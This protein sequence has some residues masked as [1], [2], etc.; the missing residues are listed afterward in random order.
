MK[1]G[2][3]KVNEIH[4]NVRYN[5]KKYFELQENIKMSNQMPLV[6]VLMPCYNHDKYLAQAIDSV[7]A[8]TYPNIELLIMDNASTDSSYE[9]MKQYGDKIKIFRL[10]KNDVFK[11]MYILRTNS[12]GKYIAPI[13]ADD[14]W[15]IDKIEKQVRYLEDN[16]K[17]RAC[18]TWANVVDDNGNLVAD[19]GS[20]ICNTFFAQ[21]NRSRYAWLE[22]LIIGGN[23]LSYP[24]AMM[25][26]NAY[27]DA[28]GK[29]PPVWQLGDWNIWLEILLKGD[30]HIIEEE[31]TY[32]RWHSR[33]T[34]QNVSAPSIKSIIRT[35]NEKA[36]IAAKIINDMDEETFIKTFQKYFVRPEALGYRE[37]LCEKFFLL[38]ALASRTC[39][40]EQEV[41]NFYY[42]H[43]Q[44]VEQEGYLLKDALD[45]F[46]DYSLN[47][48]VEYCAGHGFG[49][50]NIVK[51]QEQNERIQLAK[52]NVALL[53]RFEN[54]SQ[55]YKK[56]EC[57]VMNQQRWLDALNLVMK[58]DI[59]ESK[60]N[61]VI[62]NL[63]YVS[64]ADESKELVELILKCIENIAGEIS[65]KN[66]EELQQ[67]L[68]VMIET[69][70][71]LK[72]ALRGIWIN[73]LS[74]DTELN[75]DEWEDVIVKIENNQVDENYFIEI[76]LPF[77]VNTYAILSEYRG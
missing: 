31:L 45:E 5:I 7:L 35:N 28:M 40:Y 73:F 25:H 8:Q 69:V 13:S 10:E 74:L 70:G 51:N 30:I 71:L 72:V 21:K 17:V 26:R 6:S 52:S 64:L 59:P 12:C 14:Y 68:G 61:S 49:Y 34:D 77:L 47:D 11:A 24:S 1:S 20:G 54:L 56:Q 33:G 46:Y 41:M 67:G 36:I 62:R 22:R 53:E 2:I 75:K 38:Q 29:M 50:V 57:I 32:F 55:A 19:D 48:F 9:V 37:I 16:T 42:Q 23:C 65:S 18:F 66:D 15:A 27:F 43:N 60:R 76:V 39:E 3:K 44:N 58:M 4:V 63:V